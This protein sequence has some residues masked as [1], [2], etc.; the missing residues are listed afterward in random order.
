MKFNFGQWL[1]SFG[2]SMLGLL[3][4]GKKVRASDVEQA[5]ASSAIDEAAK[6][7]QPKP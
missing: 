5:A 6:D 7:N 3:S 1:A 4:M 2:G